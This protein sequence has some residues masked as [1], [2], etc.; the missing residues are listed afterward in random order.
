[1]KLT[2]AIEILEDILRYVKPGDPTDEHDAIKLGI[3][4]LTTIKCYRVD[5]DDDRLLLLPGETEE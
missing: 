3:K 2:K 4:A 1:M 5:Q